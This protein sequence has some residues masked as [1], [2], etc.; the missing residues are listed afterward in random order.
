MTPVIITTLYLLLPISIQSRSISEHKIE[1]LNKEVYQ[2]HQEMKPK[3]NFNIISDTIEKTIR[4]AEKI[5][6]IPKSNTTTEVS[7]HDCDQ[8]QVSR[9]LNELKESIKNEM[10]QLQKL[11]LIAIATVSI[12]TILLN[13]IG[14]RLLSNAFHRAV[15]S[16][17]FTSD[18]GERKANKR[19][20]GGATIELE[21]VV[22]PGV[23]YDTIEK[24][25]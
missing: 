17:P 19:V 11:V 14:Q 23:T 7:S 24:S 18:Y 1:A 10:E 21:Q 22:T 3:E 2:M 20:N 9:T 6:L 15:K 25:S 4:I 5:G 13:A 12:V 8:E 16:L